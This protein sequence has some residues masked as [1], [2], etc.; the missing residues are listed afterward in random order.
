MDLTV[1][2]V[3]GA[4]FRKKLIHIMALS[5]AFLTRVVDYIGREQI[6]KPS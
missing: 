5:T 3:V 1:L 2:R 6:R 4:T